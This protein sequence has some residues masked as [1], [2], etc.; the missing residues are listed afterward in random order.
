MIEVLDDDFTET[1]Y[2]C[3][4]DVVF[5]ECMESELMNLHATGTAAQ[6][7]MPKDTLVVEGCPDDMHEHVVQM[8]SLDDEFDM[9]AD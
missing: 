2:A 6:L 8:N 5:D 9:G 3:H 7:D 4:D 1:A